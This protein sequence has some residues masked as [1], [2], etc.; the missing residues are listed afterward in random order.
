MDKLTDLRIQASLLRV[1]IRS[2]RESLRRHERHIERLRY[3]LRACENALVAVQT[4]L[5][6]NGWARSPSSARPTAST[7]PDSQAHAND[8]FG[9]HTPEHDLTA[10]QA[11]GDGPRSA[12]SEQ[13]Q[14]I[15]PR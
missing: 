5:D 3:S 15:T 9:K 2:A 13:D 4:A 1:D 14:P 10:G 8:G 7:R 12:A 6:A 11:L